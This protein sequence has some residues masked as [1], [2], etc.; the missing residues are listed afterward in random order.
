MNSMEDEADVMY[1]RMYRAFKRGTGMHLSAAEIEL[2]GYSLVGEW[3]S[4]AAEK[5][6]EQKTATSGE[7]EK[8]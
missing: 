4:D 3:M 1:A 2:L 6:R 8:G 5:V 7:G